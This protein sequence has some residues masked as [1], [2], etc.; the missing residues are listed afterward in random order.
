MLGGVAVLDVVDD[1]IA[2]ARIEV[3]V[4][5]R[6]AHTAG[7]EEALEEE[8]VGDGIDRGDAENVGD[9]GVGGRASTGA[10]DTV[11][12]REAHDIPDTE[13][14]GGQSHL[15]D[16]RELVGEL[17]AD[18]RGEGAIKLAHAFLQRGRDRRRRFPL[19]VPGNRGG[20]R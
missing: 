6:H 11:L 3:D 1:L 7:I 8:V 10:A 13:K 2:A 14:E 18:L 16:D 15:L 17:I 20:G 9:D 5:I 4:D 12:A 19:R